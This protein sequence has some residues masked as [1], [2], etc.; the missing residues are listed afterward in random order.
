M[1]IVPVDL[2]VPV[3]AI[4]IF[5]ACAQS[6]PPKGPPP[7]EATAAVGE[8][9]PASAP[10]VASAQPVD[11]RDPR[12]VLKRRFDGETPMMSDLS[13]LCD[14]IGGR[15]T[16]SPAAERAVKW[17]TQKFRAMGIDT[18]RTEKFR[19]P[20]LWL[21][22]RAEVVETA[23]D[24][25]SIEAVASPGTVSLPSVE[26]PLLDVEDGTPEALAKLGPK[27]AGA[28]L[29]LRTK[30]AKTVEDLFSEYVRTHPLMEA[31]TRARV[32]GL[33]I[34]SAEPRGLFYEHRMGFG[35]KPLTPA[36]V[37][38]S[39][40][41]GAR[42]SRLLQRSQ[43]RLRVKVTNHIGPA[44]ESENVIAEVRGSGAPDEVVILGAHL[45]SWALGTGAEDN[46]VNSALVLDVARAFHEL[47]LVPRRTVRFVLFTGEEQLM[48]GSSGYVAR[49]KAEMAKHVAS[50]TF[51]VGS[52]RTSGFVLNG[53][54]ELRAPVLKALSVFP[55]FTADSHIVDSVFITDSLPFMLSGVSNL[56]AIQDDKPYL[57]VFHSSSD[58]FDYVDAKEA[59]R[60]AAIAAVLT[61]WLADTRDALPGQLTRAEVDQ[62]LV[63][64]KTVDELKAFDLW[65]DWQQRRIGF[66]AEG[67]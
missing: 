39:R 16:G 17:A 32:A 34:Q 59:K 22:E 25:F 67:K 10:V 21:P 56:V 26:A 57:P 14:N 44:F 1:R 27:A 18:V 55:E 30:E 43:V 45:D 31:A 54:P 64:T 36:A 13:E 33:I 28:F 8:S 40:E 20:F 61:W 52:G 7:V 62:I 66:P 65:D 6:S 9:A 50:I 11:E 35:S 15:I 63:K 24:S 46:G 2:V 49:H 47:K 37:L 60:N 4:S 5:G 38:V 51:D 41:Q 42:L 19:A 12:V 53:R 58:V 3:L 48:W 29:L 23:P